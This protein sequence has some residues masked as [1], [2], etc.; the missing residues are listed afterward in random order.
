MRRYSVSG[1]GGNCKFLA[2]GSGGSTPSRRTQP[3]VAQWAE[4]LNNDGSN[5]PV[6]TVTQICR[7]SHIRKR[8]VVGSNPA[9]WKNCASVAQSVGG[10]RFRI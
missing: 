8:V 3:T 10:V 2:S 7:S 1:S 9:C 5:Y 6:E 4:H